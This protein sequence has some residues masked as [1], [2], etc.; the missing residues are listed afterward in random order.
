M[1]FM[2]GNIEM[3]MVVVVLYSIGALSF[4]RERERVDQIDRF[5]EVLRLVS[6]KLRWWN[7]RWGE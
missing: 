4:M 2:W 6:K 7:K 3:V 1:V 5:L